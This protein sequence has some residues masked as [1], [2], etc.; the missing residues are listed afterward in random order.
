M[1]IIY[2]RKTKQANDID[3][4]EM[5]SLIEKLEFDEKKTLFKEDTG[6]EIYVVRPSKIKSKLKNNYE[7]EKNFQ[8]WLNY[9]YREFRPNH[10]RVLIDLNLRA[11]SKPDTKKD[12]LVAFDNIYYGKDPTIEVKNLNDILFPHCLNSIKITANLSQLF[13]IEQDFN[14]S[15]KSNFDPKTLFYQGWVREFIDSPKEIDNMC[16]SVAKGQPPKAQYTNKENKKLFNKYINDLRPL[17]YI[18]QV[19]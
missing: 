9:N 11:R 16:F 14:Y 17:W 7:L 19:V 12:L 10:L 2:I 1:V 5:L 13:L 6:A 3:Y 18:N 8:I 15:G 4:N